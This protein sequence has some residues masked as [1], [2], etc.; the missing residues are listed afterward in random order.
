MVLGDIRP[1]ELITRAF[2]QFLERFELE[3]YV[4]MSILFS[5]HIIACIPSSVTLLITFSSL[6]DRLISVNSRTS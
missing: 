5:F 1:A 3:S 2:G 6:S 4:I